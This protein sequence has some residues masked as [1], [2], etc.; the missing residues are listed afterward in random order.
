MASSAFRLSTESLKHV[1]GESVRV[2]CDL[3]DCQKMAVLL[4]DPEQ[5]AL[6][7]HPPAEGVEEE[8]LHE[9]EVSLKEPSLIGT[10]YRTN[11]PMTSNEASDDEWVS[12]EMKGALD[13][14]NLLVAPVT[15]GPQPIG[16]L[17]AI[18]SKRGQFTEDECRR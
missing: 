3:L 6:I 7:P 11:T 12:D 16:V 18:N 9:L 8:R 13:V 4:H 1:V 2:V 15:S 17:V 5:G 14:E 10:V